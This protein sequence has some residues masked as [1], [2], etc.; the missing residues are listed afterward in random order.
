MVMIMMNTEK[1]IDNLINCIGSIENTR[2]IK[3]Y[4]N[5][6]KPTKIT[7]AYI[8]IGIKEIKLMPYQLDYP[9]KAGELTM[10]A[11]LFCPLNWDSNEL[12]KLFSK[13]C[14]AV[15]KFNITSISTEEVTADMTTQA[16][17]LKTTITFYNEFDFGGD[18]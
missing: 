18:A 17:M 7:K 13:L 5:N 10:S 6:N 16:Y 14:T 12:T 4:P 11:D 15:E 2:I 8:A 9:D 3:A 1:A